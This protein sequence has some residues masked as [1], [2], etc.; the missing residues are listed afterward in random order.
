[1]R[2]FY[3]GTLRL[4]LVLLHDFPD[5]LCHFNFLL[6]EE[7]PDN[8]MQV[9]NI[10]VSAYPKGMKIPDPFEVDS[11]N[12]AE[13][14]E[15]YTKLP[16]ANMKVDDRISCHNLQVD[17]L[18]LQVH[19][20]NCIKKFEQA[21]F[22]SIMKSFYIYGY[23]ND[24][25]INKMLLDSFVLYV[26]YFIYDQAQVEGLDH[27]QTESYKHDSYMLFVK[28]MKAADFELRD[29]LINSMFNN[30]RYPNQITFY[31]INLL[32]LFFTSVDNDQI[33]EQIIKYVQSN[34]E[35]YSRD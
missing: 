27:Q 3:K 28:I 20:S 26:P 30:L 22:D 23:K 13:M 8:F 9:K 32:I 15:E 34:L 35:T 12:R 25:H 17:R 5:F 1:M 31:F 4:L 19:I 7:I 21:D 16:P 2:Y 11:Q 14:S 6:L 33:Q 10:M 24:M 29:A 18:L